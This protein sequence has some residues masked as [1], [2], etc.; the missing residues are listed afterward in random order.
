[1]S[2]HQIAEILVDKGITLFNSP[3]KFNNFS[4]DFQADKLLNDLE[5]KPH[6]FVLA[7]VM[8]RQIKAERAWL[9]PYRISQKLGN[10]EFH[11]LEVLTLEETEELMTIPE[12]LHRF[13]AEMAKNFFSAIQTITEKY[14][15]DA[16]NI[17][18]GKPSSAEVVYRFLE[19]R[20]IGQKIGTMAVNILARDFKVGFSDYYSIDISVDVHIRR[21]FKRLGLITSD[22]TSEQIIY[23]VRALSPEF[24]GLLDLPAWEIGR[25]WCKPSEPNCPECYM[26]RVCQKFL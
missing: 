4:G 2:V 20:G 25:K 13:P 8:D 12:H 15:G 5:N 24:P 6:A 10:F 9:I 23:R 17:W 14:H 1:M 7:C 26:Y 3:R 21:V 22:A 11:T 16:S 19:F 18:I